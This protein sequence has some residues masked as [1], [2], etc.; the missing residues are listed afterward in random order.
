VG[1]GA[2]LVEV[3]VEGGLLG[4]REGREMS[5][6]A[7]GKKHRL[8]GNTNGK[9]SKAQSLDERSRFH[10]SARLNGPP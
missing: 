8:Q 6:S 5:G 7:K 3:E 1:S 2:A 10:E 9:T 4:Y